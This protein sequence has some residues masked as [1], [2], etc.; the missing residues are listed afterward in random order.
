VNLEAT[1]PE[2]RGMPPVLQDMALLSEL[3]AGRRPAL[4]LI[5]S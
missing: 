3:L 1:G 4:F 2:L 5:G